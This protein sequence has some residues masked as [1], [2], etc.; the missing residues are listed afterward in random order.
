MHLPF[1]VVVVIV[2]IV[3]NGVGLGLENKA[4]IDAVLYIVLLWLFLQTPMQWGWGNKTGWIPCSSSNIC[5]IITINIFI[6]CVHLKRL[7]MQ[8]SSVAKGTPT[9]DHQSHFPPSLQPHKKRMK[10]K[11][12]PL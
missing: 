4:E 9:L 11:M 6:V 10:N 1:F 8:K 5:I 7:T 2:V 3:I 12:H